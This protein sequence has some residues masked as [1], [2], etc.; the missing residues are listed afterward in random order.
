MGLLLPN[1]ASFRHLP[2][3]PCTFLWLTGYP[4]PFCG[5][6]RSFWAMTLGDWAFAFQNSP[7]ACLV[8]VM[9]ALVF[10]WNATGLLLGLRLERGKFLRLRPGRGRWTIGS[11]T[12]LVLLNWAY[13]LILGLK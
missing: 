1:W 4:C 2:S 8:Y 7:L 13:R 10:A 11:L 3:M 12:L 6:T 9:A 5:F